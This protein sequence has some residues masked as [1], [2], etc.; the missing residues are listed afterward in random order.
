MYSNFIPFE[1]IVQAVKDETGIT[2]TRNLRPLIRRLMF[3]IE[4][5]IGFGYNLVLKRVKYSLANGTINRIGKQSHVKLPEDIIKIESF[6]MCQ[7]GICPADYKIQGNILFLCK[8]ITEFSFIYWTLLC[9]EEGNPTTTLNHKEAIVSG[10][11]YYMYKPKVYQRKGSAGY[12]RELQ[13]Y[14]EQRVGEARG[15]DAMPNTMEEWKEISDLLKMSQKQ[16]II[17]DQKENCYCSIEDSSTELLEEKEEIYF[18]QFD[19]LGLNIN[20]APDLTLEVIK[21]KESISYDSFSNGNTFNYNSIG[22][23]AFAFVNI[24]QGKYRIYDIL[25]NDVT[26]IVFDNYYNNDLKTDIYVSKEHITYSNIFYE[27]KLN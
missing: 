14:Y 20:N 6:G 17:Y 23:I 1:E 27:L 19:D 11:A 9:D 2:N 15:D 8:D 22:R 24:N 25:G 5:D 18:W 4:Q 16:L 21:S 26:D 12:L 3:K 7:E 13:F 10:C